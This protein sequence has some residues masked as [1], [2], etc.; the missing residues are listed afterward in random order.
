MRMRL[1]HT[2][3]LSRARTETSKLNRRRE[4]QAE[5]HSLSTQRPDA[6]EPGQSN[7]RSRLH[8]LRAPRPKLAELHEMIIKER[9]ADLNLEALRFH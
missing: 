7:F 4:A 5:Y 6:G 9:F 3:H 1:A 2:S 8:G